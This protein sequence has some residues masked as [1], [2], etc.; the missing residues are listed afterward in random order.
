MKPE[1]TSAQALELLRQQKE[2]WETAGNSYSALAQVKVKELDFDIFKIKVQ[3]NPARI[4]SSAAKVDAKSLQERKCFLC[5][6]NLPLAQEGLPFGDNYQVLINPFPIF[7]E[8]LTIPV[9]KHENQRILPRYADMLDLAKALDR[10]TIFYNGPKCGASAPDHAHFQAGNKGFLPIEKDWKIVDQEL[11]YMKSGTSLYVLKN[12]LRNTLVIESENKEES[13]RLFERIYE[14]LDVKDGEDEPMVN[15][16]AWYEEGWWV[17]CLFPRRKHRPICY[18]A[19]GDDNIL[20]SPASVDMGGVFI[21]PLEKDFNKI[22]KADVSF[23]LKEVSIS[24]S[25]MDKLIARLN[26]EL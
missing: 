5:L 4:I 1:V 15:I 20:F 18:F 10:F 13:V 9:L 3:F 6:D 25:D 7:P 21:T 2:S 14:Q 17:T 11:V 8:H 19:E 12:Y 16:L 26:E 22:S 23:I 24:N